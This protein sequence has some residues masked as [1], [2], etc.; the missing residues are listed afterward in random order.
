MYHWHVG[1]WLGAAI[2]AV[3]RLEATDLGSLSGAR[4]RDACVRENIRGR[5]H[6]NYETGPAHVLLTKMWSLS[7]PEHPWMLVNLETTDSLGYPR[8]GPLVRSHGGGHRFESGSACQ[9]SFL[10][11]D[12]L[13]RPESYDHTLRSADAAI[14]EQFDSV[15]ARQKEED[16]REAFGSG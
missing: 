13:F 14:P 10:K 8:T 16:I 2:L 1:L 12:P 4:Q 3:T 9:S 7:F 15:V 5:E 11:R 6:E